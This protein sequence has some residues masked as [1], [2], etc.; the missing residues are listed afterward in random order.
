MSP[1]MA[2][3]TVKTLLRQQILLKVLLKTLNRILKRPLNRKLLLK[4][5]LGH[6]IKF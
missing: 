1:I 3:K 6:Q 2:A 4:R 5:R